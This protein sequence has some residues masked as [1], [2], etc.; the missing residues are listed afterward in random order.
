MRSEVQLDLALNA[1]LGSTLIIGLIFANYVRKFTIDRFQRYIFCGLLS[2]IFISMMS[3]FAYMLLEGLPGRTVHLSLYAFG[4]IYYFFQVLAYYYIIVFIDYMVF[5]DQKRTETII[6]IVYA[7]TVIHALV[8]LLNLKHHFYF[9]IAGEGNVF[10]RGDKYYIL[11]LLS[12]CPA[13]FAAYDFIISHTV[14]KKSF[15]VMMA[16]LLLFP[17]AGSTVDLIVGSV[18]LIWPCMAAALLYAYFF[19]IQSDTRLDSLTGIGNRFSFNEFT[20]KLS[21]RASGESWSFV[22]IDM[23]NFKNINDSLGHQEGDNALRDMAF[24]IK[25]CI[26]GSDFAA[27]YGG[28]EFIL[29]ARTKNGTEILMQRI[30][31][32]VDQHNAKHSRPF[33]LEISY[34][35]GVYTADGGQTIEGLLAYIDGQ[36]YKHKEERRRAGDKLIEAAT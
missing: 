7:I 20:D 33:K 6:A 22:L 4:T 9:Y 16:L 18:K 31:E 10:N 35:H 30:Q 12:Y 8:L 34:G 11:L 15:L 36:M 26:R 3:D 5:K 2:F 21:R 17:F 14:F 25:N 1:V 27:R 32:A 13:I 19:I 23:D 28:D 24:I 29:A